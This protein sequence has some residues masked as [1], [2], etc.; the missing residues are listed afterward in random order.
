V[1]VAAAGDSAGCEGSGAGFSATSLSADSSTR[2]GG[3]VCVG[4]VICGT[5]SACGAVAFGACGAVA[6]GAGFS[7]P[8]EG[9]GATTEAGGTAGLARDAPGAVPPDA[10]D[11]GAARVGDTA[12]GTSSGR[13]AAVFGPGFAGTAEGGGTAEEAGAM[14]GLAIDAPGA[15]PPAIAEGGSVCVGDAV[16]SAPGVRGATACGPGFA[17]TAD[18][19]GTA[20]GAG[21]LAGLAIDAPGAMAPAAPD[22]GGVCVGDAV[23]GAALACVAAAIATGFTGTADGVAALP[24]S[25]GMPAFATDV[26]GA[27]MAAAPD[28]GADPDTCTGPD[29]GAAARASSST[30]TTTRPP[31][32]QA[33]TT[34]PVATTSSACPAPPVKP[35]TSCGMDGVGPTVTSPVNRTTTCAPS[36]V[37]L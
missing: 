18:G 29:G 2:P 26:P 15:M 33:C 31:S 21:D 6:F 5:V 20:D 10:P 11:G 17:G 7:G 36:C 8:A 23:G 35:S 13:D 14:A 4:A 27:E 19:V 3:V 37:S 1:A 30:S 16:G 12:G 25:A 22:G 28:C 32:R 34:V 24:V 9:A